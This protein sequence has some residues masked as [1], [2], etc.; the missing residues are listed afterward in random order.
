MSNFQSLYT[1]INVKGRRGLSHRDVVIT[2][3][4]QLSIDLN[5]NGLIIIILLILFSKLQLGL[6]YHYILNCKMT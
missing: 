6:E 3:W 5:K 2:Y 1:H 4:V